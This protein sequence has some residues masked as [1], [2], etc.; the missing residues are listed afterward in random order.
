MIC[1][2][3]MRLWA[4]LVSARGARSVRPA[5]PAGSAG[6]SSPFVA[7]PSQ[8]PGGRRLECRGSRAEAWLSLLS[9]GGSG[10]SPEMTFRAVG[11]D[12]SC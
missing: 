11:Q 3:A 5:P 7:W 10:L 9:S 8:Q 4:R 12:S 1:R 2:S 6:L